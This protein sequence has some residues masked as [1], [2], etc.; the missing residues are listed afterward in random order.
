MIKFFISEV[1]YCFGRW[2]CRE[3]IGR[4][5]IRVKIKMYN[6]F[7]YIDNRRKKEGRNEEVG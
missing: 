7:Y 3:G 1:L 4:L 6:F 5:Y 2:R